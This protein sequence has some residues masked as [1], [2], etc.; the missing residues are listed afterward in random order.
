MKA[1]HIIKVILSAI[2]SI[3][4]LLSAYVALSSSEV[5]LSVFEKLHLLAYKNALGV[6]DIIIALSLWNKKTRS[7]GILVGTA[8]LGG[9]IA[10]ELSSGS[11][12]V[13]PAILLIILWVMYK[14]DLRKKCSCGV[15]DTCVIKV[16]ATE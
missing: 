10:S 6:I 5:S 3:L 7:I 2:L 4:F 14:I 11:T 16:A 9:A 12:G 8:Y 15:C 13:I 1:S